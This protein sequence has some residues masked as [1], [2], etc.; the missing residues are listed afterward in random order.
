MAD[1]PLTVT[2]TDLFST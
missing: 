1:Q 2:L